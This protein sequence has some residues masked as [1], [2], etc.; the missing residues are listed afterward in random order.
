MGSSSGGVRLLEAQS[1]AASQGKAQT[2]LVV[3]VEL[4]HPLKEP[5]VDRPLGRASTAS[6]GLQSSQV[7]I[8]L[9]TDDVLPSCFT[10]KN[11]RQFQMCCQG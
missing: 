9:N 1:K 10:K 5:Q 4:R 2:S 3:I 8:T 7:H 11:H 6:P